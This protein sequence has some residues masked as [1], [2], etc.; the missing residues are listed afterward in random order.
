MTLEYLQEVCRARVKDLGDYVK[1]EIQAIYDFAAEEV[2]AG[3]S[4]Y[5]EVEL[6][7]DALDELTDNTGE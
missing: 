3:E 1:D 7:L 6:A 5:H 2:E 4:E